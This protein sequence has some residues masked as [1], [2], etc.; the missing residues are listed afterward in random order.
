MITSNVMDLLY[1][2]PLS[3]T[4][5]PQ[6]F[7]VRRDLKTISYNLPCTHI[8]SID[9]TT[10]MTSIW[11]LVEAELSPEAKAQLDL[12]E[13]AHAAKQPISTPIANGGGNKSTISTTHNNNNNNKRNGMN[14]NY[15]RG[16]NN[17]KPRGR[18]TTTRYTNELFYADTPETRAY[19]ARMAVEQMYFTLFIKIFSRTLCL[20]SFVLL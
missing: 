4:W 10:I 12:A 20:L 14:G 8:E 2:P 5:C 16:N 9:I 1:R 13:K 11:K 6:L 19:Y 17:N 18:N 3:T 15:G 7:Q